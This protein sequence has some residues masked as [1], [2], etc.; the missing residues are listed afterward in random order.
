MRSR[1]LLVAAAI[2]AFSQVRAQTHA[3]LAPR[4]SLSGGMGVE[5]ATYP[6]VTGLVNVTALPSERVPQFKSA[7]EFFGAFALP[8]SELWLLKFEYAYTLG[9]WSPLGAFGPASFSVTTHMPSVILQY[10]L[11][12]R[13]VYN[14]RVGV[15]GGYHFGSLGEK[16]LSLD[17]TF[18]G[19]GAGMVLELEANTAFGDH[20]FAFLGG[21]IRWEF[22]GPLLDVS[23]VS[24]GVGSGG[25]GVTL[26][27]FGVG[28]R[29]G[30][31]YLF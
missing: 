8:L 9:S 24:P 15:G 19:K 4:V 29:L 17:D 13:G 30:A 20:L 22:I 26:H 14:V 1:L 25:S 31:C 5:Y 27:S 7:V 11:T 2:C 21:N 6:D 23:G 3:D 16:Y 12:D 28:A 10:M 18:N